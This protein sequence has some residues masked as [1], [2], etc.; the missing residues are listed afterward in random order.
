MYE[1]LD[2]KKKDG[3]KLL[4]DNDWYKNEK[5]FTE[6]RTEL[7]WKLVSKDL[8]PNSTSKNYLEQTGILADYV[9]GLYGTEEMPKDVKEALGEWIALK[10]NKKEFKKLQD[11]TVSS[12]EAEWKSAADTLEKLKLTQMFRES[13]IEWFYRTALT[14]RTTGERLLPNTYSWTKSRASSGDFVRAGDFYDGGGDV[15]RSRPRYSNSNLGCA[16]SA[17]KL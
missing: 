12:D 9:V 14:E 2:K 4:Y 13:F 8:I 15:Y 16:F 10:N 17:V 11:N 5:F 6:E 7:R 3:T 1:N